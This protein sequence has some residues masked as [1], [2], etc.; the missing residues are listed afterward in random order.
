MSPS[1][2]LRLPP[3]LITQVTQNLLADR[4]SWALSELSLTH[5]AFREP[6][7]RALLSNLVVT[8]EGGPNSSASFG[9][10]GILERFQSNPRFAGYIKH[11][12][13]E[14]FYDKE[15]HE[16]EDY[17][18][19]NH[20]DI[21]KTI[22][23]ILQ[24]LTAVR[25]LKI[26]GDS[27]YGWQP[28]L[29]GLERLKTARDFVAAHRGQI[30][31][32]ELVHFHDMPVL[33][34]KEL[35]SSVQHIKLHHALDY[36]RL[37][38]DDPEQHITTIQPLKSLELLH[39]SNA[40][41]LFLQPEF[42]PFV[43]GSLR[44]LS[45]L[46]SSAYGDDELCSITAKTLEYL[47][48]DFTEL[49]IRGES[50]H[51]PLSLPPALPCL[52]HIQLQVSSEFGHYLNI[53]PRFLSALLSSTGCPQLE[54]IT[55]KVAWNIKSTNE[56]DLYHFKS[57]V[58]QFDDK[59][60][61]R[62]ATGGRAPI[63]SWLLV[64][65]SR[66]PYEG[67]P[68][69]LEMIVETLKQGMSYAFQRGLL[70]WR[71]TEDYK[72]LKIAS[73]QSVTTVS[74]STLRFVLVDRYRVVQFELLP[75]EL[76]SEILTPALR[77]SDEEFAYIGSLPFAY[78]ESKSA[79]L[80]VCKSWLRVATVL[81][82]NVVVLRSRAQAKALADAISSNQQLGGFI[83]KLRVDGGYGP[84]MHTI[85]KLSPNISDL[86]L[87]FEVF[88]GDN[89][90]GLCKGLELISPTRLI[91]FERPDRVMMN[92]M[93]LNLVQAVIK[94]I[95]GWEK[96]RVFQYS[97]WQCRQRL[98]AI[99][100]SL[101]LVASIESVVV[102]SVYDAQR[103][104]KLLKPCPLREIVITKP[105]VNNLHLRLHEFAD[106]LASVDP[107]IK[108]TI[109]QDSRTQ[110]HRSPSA[111]P[112]PLYL[113]FRPFATAP[114]EVQNTLWSRILF[115]AMRVPE[116][117]QGA[118]IKDSSHLLC[119]SRQFYTLG[120]PHY[121]THVVFRTEECAARL[122][123][124]LLR[125][126]TLATQIQTIGNDPDRRLGLIDDDSDTEAAEI[127]P[128]AFDGS[129]MVAVLSR[130]TSLRKFW[131]C[132]PTL[133]HGVTL[134]RAAFWA[135]AINSG[136]CL[137][138]LSTA[139]FSALTPLEADVFEHF[140]ALQTLDWWSEQ[141]VAISSDVKEDSLGALS[142]MQVYNADPSFFDVLCNFDLSSLTHLSVYPECPVPCREFWTTRQHGA[143]LVHL[144][145]A[146]HIVRVAD[147]S[148]L[149]VCPNLHSL[150]L[151][152]PVFKDDKPL[153]EGDLIAS[154][155][156][157]TLTSINFQLLFH[158]RSKALKTAWIDYF[159]AFSL[160]SL[161]N[162]REIVISEGMSWPTTA[163]EIAKN[164]WVRAAERFLKAGVS[165]VDEQGHRWRT[166]LKISSKRK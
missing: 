58:Q 40:Y 110:E 112:E 117:A 130:A 28:Q 87:T 89:T 148:I 18:D 147:I 158:F 113:T 108:Y 131:L 10:E 19:N 12:T 166:R 69:T 15:Q 66:V 14:M 9:A 120:I 62:I 86:Y 68:K 138:E 77:V 104:Q 47:V 84:S 119:V 8:Y 7:Q 80:L 123:H 103:A 13:I 2:V 106:F 73:R 32:L 31:S 142:R 44:G 88:T 5:S 102:E 163:R 71:H 37:K 115:W 85:L 127:V 57:F 30:I 164:G 76:L 129:A 128:C 4:E 151:L 26:H 16:A 161:P 48:F 165:M 39:T 29:R 125:H 156:T 82:Y 100:D 1:P 78:T 144:E 135:L 61:L 11:L 24:S 162:L 52:R 121:Y 79:Y 75:D 21:Y 65:H 154:Q 35:F 67:R 50:T 63:C 118:I 146:P 114:I 70:N 72:E 36:M 95:K 25:H 133:I 97:H 46:S 43:V 111:P 155:P 143:R 51:R 153:G 41:D 90:D 20:H 109:K 101:N 159:L 141:P 81:L 59:M 34:L 122:T 124:V 132:R 27:M 140:E 23:T 92:K 93:V 105:L 150:T 136:S 83:K 91:V 96:L 33:I 6:S 45:Y 49:R 94:A 139:L 60:A 116:R 98:A 38:S 107:P 3:E 157:T 99:S 152:F 64:F 149:D 54:L 53:G 137:V 126:P 22:E 42:S 134:S 56:M 145:I 74:S 55:V 160:Q 17:D